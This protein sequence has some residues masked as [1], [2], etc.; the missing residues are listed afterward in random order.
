MQEQDLSLDVFRQQFREVSG[1]EV[2]ERQAYRWLVGEVRKLPYPHARVAL[3]KMFREP[4]KNLLG[5]P[6]R[7]PSAVS[8]IRAITS[9][10][11][12]DYARNDWEGQ[13]ISMSAD[14]ARDF[15]AKAETTNVGPGTI[16]QLADDVRR[17]VALR[18]WSGLRDR[19]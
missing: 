17:L 7:Y 16:D 15:M 5:P 8:S 9:E 14:R 1:T 3:E 12:R 2:S 11:R 10:A 4:A 19:L 6:L 18:S 13:L